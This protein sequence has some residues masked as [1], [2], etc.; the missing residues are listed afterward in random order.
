VFSQ[1]LYRR[2]QGMAANC[3]S[4]TFPA[5][6]DCFHTTTLLPTTIYP[7]KVQPGLLLFGLTF[8]FPRPTQHWPS[9]S[10]THLKL[11]LSTVSPMQSAVFRLGPLSCSQKSLP[12]SGYFAHLRVF[13]LSIDFYCDLLQILQRLFCL[14]SS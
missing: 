6:A 3:D 12:R 9:Q 8:Q 2:E 7:T 11:A 4:Q 10:A 14:L 13:T 1:L 5:Y